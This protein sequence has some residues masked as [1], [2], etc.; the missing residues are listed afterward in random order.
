MFKRYPRLPR[1]ALPGNTQ[2]QA[3]HSRLRMTALE[4]V[5]MDVLPEKIWLDAVLSGDDIQFFLTLQDFENEVG[6]ELC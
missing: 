4:V 2:K 5:G 6:L 1:K 3:V